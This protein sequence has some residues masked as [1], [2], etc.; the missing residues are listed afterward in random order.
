MAMTVAHLPAPPRSRSPA[1]HSSPSGAWPVTALTCRRNRSSPSSRLSPTVSTVAGTDAANTAPS[2]VQSPGCTVNS[3]STAVKSSPATALSFVV[4]TL[5][6]YAA[7]GFGMPAA[8]F[9]VSAAVASLPSA[10]S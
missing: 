8:V 5:T 6:L 1:G 10:T 9:S 4:N 7:R 3:T 2:A